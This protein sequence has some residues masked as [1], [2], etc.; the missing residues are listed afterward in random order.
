MR[1]YLPQTWTLVGEND[2]ASLTV[3][4]EGHDLVTP[5][6]ASAPDVTV[7]ASE[8]VLLSALRARPDGKAR[9]PEV[10]VTTRTAKGK[11]AFDFLRGRFGL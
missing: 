10:S 11:A 9:R 4:R 5:G 6:R 8:A 7:E 2:A 3:D 1:A